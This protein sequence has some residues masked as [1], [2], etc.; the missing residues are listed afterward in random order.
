MDLLSLLLFLALPAYFALRLY[1]HWRR[2]S[3][4]GR[5][6]HGRDSG[7]SLATGLAGVFLFDNLLNDS[8]SSGDAGTCDADSGGD[9]GCG[10]SGGGDGGGGDG[11]GGD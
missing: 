8:G 4:G 10:D 11:G 6:P 1:F 9:S 7:A 2:R 3:S 5:P